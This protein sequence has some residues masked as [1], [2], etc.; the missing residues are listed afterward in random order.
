[1][2]KKRTKGDPDKNGDSDLIS[3]SPL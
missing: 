2:F 3:K 1:M